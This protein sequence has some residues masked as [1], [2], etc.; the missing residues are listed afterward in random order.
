M[1]LR[2]ALLA[3]AI[4]LLFST[5]GPTIAA[6]SDNS[7]WNVLKPPFDTHAVTISTEQTTWSSLSVSPD[8]SYMVFDMLNLNCITH[9]LSLLKP[10]KVLWR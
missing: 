9:W 7:D 4:G 5:A 2:R 10:W 3:S 1:P 8:G 6:E